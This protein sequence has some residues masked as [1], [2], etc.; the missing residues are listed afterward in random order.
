MPC[1]H[2]RSISTL[3]AS[4]C[5]CAKAART[6]RTAT[7]SLLRRSSAA[8]VDLWRGP[9][10]PEL[11]EW[12]PGRNEA[13]RLEEL[14]RCVTEELAEL[15]LA[16]GHHHQWIPVLESLVSEEPLRERRWALLMVALYRCG[17]QADAMRAYQRARVALD[18]V[19]LEPGPELV[20]LEQRVGAHD[21]SLEHEAR[22]SSSLRRRG[23]RERD[24]GR[25]AVGNGDV[26]VHRPRGIDPLCG[27]TPE[28]AMETPLGR[29]DEILGERDR[30]P[31]GRRAQDDGRRPLR[32]LL[33]GRRRVRRRVD[34]ATG[35]WPRSRGRRRHVVGAHGSA[36]RR[37]AASATATTSGRH[38]NRAAR[39]MARWPTAVR[40]WCRSRRR[41]SSA[42]S[43]RRGIGLLDLGEH[44]LTDLA[45]PERI[46]QVVGARL[47]RRFPSLRS[48]DIRP[49]NLPYELSTF[50]GRASDS[51]SSTRC[52]AG[53]RVLTL[54]GPGERA[55]P[56]RDA[57]SRSV[58]ERYPDGVW[59]LD[60]APVSNEALIIVAS[61]G[62][63]RDRRPRQR[64]SRD[65]EQLVNSYLESRQALLVL[66]NCE[67]LVDAAARV[68]HNLVA[69][70]PGITVLTTSREALGLPGEVT[71]PVPPLSVPAERLAGLGHGC[72]FGIGRPVL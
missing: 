6:L 23:A 62:E 50:V 53:S 25:T 20:H 48:A 13:A 34:G 66:D 33:V 11:C 8:A 45:R 4:S 65:L 3:V 30:R 14:H 38:V 15:E 67:H 46:F 37:G 64:Q 55:R 17:R 22:A 5:W 28:D 68:T 60:L 12:P 24:R 47:V 51:T 54:A 27:S 19:G 41:S 44:R 18:D 61:R 49:T 10:L 36:H 29:H 43:C 32:G 9:P 26:P 42:T 59:L 56:S 71:F 70:C 72:R 2:Q 69:S 40:S 35:R 57:A 63:P 58:A 52:S 31:D 16:C 21:K 1:G 7:W 39:L